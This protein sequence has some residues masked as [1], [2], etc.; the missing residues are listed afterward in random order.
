MSGLTNTFG[1]SVG[2]GLWREN[3]GLW[4][5]AHS[6]IDGDGDVTLGSLLK[7]SGGAVLKEDSGFLLVTGTP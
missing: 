4:S 7:E 5:G 3:E 6:L 1:M 2:H